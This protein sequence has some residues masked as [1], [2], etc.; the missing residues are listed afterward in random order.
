MTA[1]EITVIGGPTTL[2]EAGRFR[3]ITDPTS[4]RQANTYFRMR[5]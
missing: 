1:P 3:L 2:I 4:M 5:R